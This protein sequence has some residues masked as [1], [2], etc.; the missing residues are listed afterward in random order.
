MRPSFGA[1]IT[2]I[3]RN[4]ETTSGGTRATTS[5]D[6]SITATPLEFRGYVGGSLQR[7]LSLGVVI[8]LSQSAAATFRT[9]GDTSSLSE[10]IQLG[11]V[12]LSMLYFFDP[13]SP[14]QIG[15]TVAG[16]DWSAS[17]VDTQTD[18]PHGGGLLAGVE[19]GYHVGIGPR[20]QLGLVGNLDLGATQAAKTFRISEVLVKSGETSLLFRVNLALSLSYY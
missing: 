5:G 11:F 10:G 6:S 3:F 20:W 2:H 18:V 4:S 7:D 1:G 13:G 8:G 15:A 12:G 16:L 9:G 17:R 14:W 19:T